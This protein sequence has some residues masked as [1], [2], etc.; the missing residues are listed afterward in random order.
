MCLC[1]QDGLQIAGIL[2]GRGGVAKIGAMADVSA[3]F[4]SLLCH[5]PRQA[6][7]MVLPSAMAAHIGVRAFSAAPLGSLPPTPASI[8]QTLLESLASGLS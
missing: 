2:G 4:R 5:A 6:S 3:A 1:V 7:G 8:T